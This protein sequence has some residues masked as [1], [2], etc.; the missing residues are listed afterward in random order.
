MRPTP[1]GGV[2]RMAGS[3][4]A[5]TDLGWLEPAGTVQGAHGTVQGQLDGAEKSTVRPM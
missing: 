5:G 4:P 3:V 2:C 1:A